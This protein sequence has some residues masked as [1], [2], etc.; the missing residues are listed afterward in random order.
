MVSYKKKQDTMNILYPIVLITLMVSSKSDS[1]P[2][3]FIA[4]CAIESPFLSSLTN[5]YKIVNIHIILN[6]LYVID[7]Y[8]YDIFIKLSVMIFVNGEHVFI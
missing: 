1:D 6:H 2:L 7:I 4:K 8:T 3:H 5:K